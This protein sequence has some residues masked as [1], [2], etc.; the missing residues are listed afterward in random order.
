ML[1]HVILY[2]WNIRY[3]YKLKRIFKVM[4]LFNFSFTHILAFL[5]SS[6]LQNNF[7]QCPD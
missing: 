6:A 3:M 4:S 5:I 7:P 2:C 1:L